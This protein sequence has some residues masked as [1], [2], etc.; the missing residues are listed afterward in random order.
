MY[1]VSTTDIIVVIILFPLLTVSCAKPEGNN[2]QNRYISPTEV[3]DAYRKARDKRDACTVFSL[4]TPQ[5]QN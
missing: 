1:N 4:L 5:T 3:F 2:P